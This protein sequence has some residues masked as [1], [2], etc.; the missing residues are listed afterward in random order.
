MPEPSVGFIPL[1]RMVAAGIAATILLSLLVVARHMILNQSIEDGHDFGAQINI[2]GRQRMLAV[3]ITD[4]AQDMVN[5]PGQRAQFRRELL[6]ASALMERSQHG[7]LHGDPDM[8]LPVKLSP[9]LRAMQFDEP[10]LLDQQITLFLKESRALAHAEEAA[11]T[12]ANPHLLYLHQAAGG[13]LISALNAQV[14]QYQLESEKHAKTVQYLDRFIMLFIL[15]VIL[16]VVLF[17]FRPIVRSIR[18]ATRHLAV[19]EERNRAVVENLADGLITI[20]P[21]GIVESFN[22]AAEKIFGYAADEVIG[23]N[24]NM[25]MPEPYKREHD[26]YL[27][28]YIDT[29]EAKILGTG[30]T[31]EGRRKDGSTFPLALTV[32]EMRIGVERKFIGTVR[33]ITER[34]AA[35]QAIASKNQELALRG[36]YDHSYARAI[37]LFSSTYDQNKALSG[38]LSILADNHP[39]PVSAIYTYDEWSGKLA[40]STS[41]GAPETL[42][43]E[44]ERGEGLIGQTLLD[45]K[46]MMLAEFDEAGLS[47]EAGVLSFQPACVIVSPIAYQDKVTA[48]LVLASSKSLTDLDT[49][50]IERLSAQ[51]GVALNALR[52]HRD[53]MDLT[54]QIR[55]RSEDITQ[56]NAQLEQANRMKSEFLANMSHELRTP[57]NAIIGFSEVLKDGVMGELTKEQTEYIGDIFNS[58]QHLLSLIND[59]LDLSKIEAGKMEL[60]LDEVIIPDLLNNSLSIIK[61]KAMA[62]RIKID[63]DVGENVEACWMDARKAKQILFNLLSNAVK[64]TPDG[65]SVHVD[66]RRVKGE[67]IGRGKDTPSP[68]THPASQD[69]DFLEISITDTGIGISEEDQQKL[70]QAFVQADASLSRE[71]EGTGLGLVMVKKLA[72]L[73]GGTVGMQSEQGKG[74]IFTIW[75]PWREKG[76]SLL[77]SEESESG[78]GLGSRPGGEINKVVR[79]SSPDPDSLTVVIVEDEEAA[80]EL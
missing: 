46:T 51:L 55:R 65:G 79:G 14:N 23:N 11:L 80:A 6:D 31:V 63:L 77:S 73:H 17:V 67:E 78:S 61:E 66:A 70:F 75:L 43:K 50:F 32:N 72:E 10:L 8:H 74:S 34:V 41:F 9:R 56:Q 52:Q 48:V 3:Q 19:S 59:I 20:N 69:A 38:L 24:L 21:S 54:E 25:L 30:R 68:L 5:F 1:R 22:P 16:L 71:Y 76:D 4:R 62:H 37:A 45:N 44:F 40:L 35:E 28:H 53:L 29:G 7:L 58:G 18:Q 42:K 13:P 33:D 64:F 49:S 60:D 15:A 27:Q 57:L 47:I 36:R 12:T 26:G 2:S 39:F